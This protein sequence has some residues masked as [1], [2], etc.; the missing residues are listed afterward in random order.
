MDFLPAAITEL[1]QLMDSHVGTTAHSGGVEIRSSRNRQ[2]EI[3]IGSAGRLRRHGLLR[4]A[5]TGSICAIC[6]SLL[7]P[8]RFLRLPGRKAGGHIS[9]RIFRIRIH[10]CTI[11]QTLR[12]ES[13]K[14]LVGHAPLGTHA[15]RSRPD[16]SHRNSGR[17]CAVRQAGNQSL[18]SYRVA[19]EPGESVLDGLCRIRA[20]QD[21]TLA[22][23]L[24]LHQRK[25]LQGMHVVAGRPCGLRLHG[26]A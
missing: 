11:Y 2:A 7:K 14:I 1:Q 10:D 6:C 18:Q 12:L 21:A 20:E 9:A 8:L 25:R 4:R 26:P 17:D 23:P 5:A 15:S 16:A 22:I 3:C 19:F 13:G 24:F